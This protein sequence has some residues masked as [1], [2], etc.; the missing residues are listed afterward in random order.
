MFSYKVLLNKNDNIRKFEEE[1]RHLFLYQ[2]LVTAGVPVSEIW[3]E[4]APLNISTKINLYQ[5]LQSRGLHV[6]EEVDGTMTI[7]A[8]DEKIG[9]FYKC[10]YILKND[11]SERNLKNRL[12]IEAEVQ[13]W[14]N[15]DI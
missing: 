5:M 2:I 9:E 6:L 4:G 14:T 15:L 8:G 3:E 10:K 12:Y 7:W 11:L 13:F 1:Q